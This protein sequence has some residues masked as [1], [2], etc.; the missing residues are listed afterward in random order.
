MHETENQGPAT[1]PG[2]GACADVQTLGIT[3]FGRRCGEAELGL[4]LLFT[5]IRG[6]HLPDDEDSLFKHFTLRVF[7]FFFFLNPP[8]HV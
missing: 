4:L 5:V 7:F 2:A 3:A 6:T 1:Q 8:I